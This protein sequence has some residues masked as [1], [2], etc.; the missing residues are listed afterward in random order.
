[1]KRWVAMAGLLALSGCVTFN[2]ERYRSERVRT[3]AV[4]AL[5]AEVDSG[6]SMV[7]PDNSSLAN[8]IN[9]VR[10][11]S[12]FA[13]GDMER[14]RAEQW[15]RVHAQ[16]NQRLTQ[17]L[18]WQTTD[19]KQIVD[20]A[21]YAQIFAQHPNDG[22]QKHALQM[23]PNLL[24]EEGFRALDPKDR[25][26]LL[27]AL[28]VDA[29][30]AVR[31]RFYVGK[32]TKVPGVGFKHMRAAAGFWVFDADSPEPLWIDTQ[33]TGEIS[34]ENTHQVLGIDLQDGETEVLA[35]AATNAFDA[36]IDRYKEWIE[37][38]EKGAPQAIR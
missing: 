25:A 36:L 31:V 7:R 23:V 30:A 29:I 18:G 9:L 1:M 33:A 13:S 12:D 24:R 5:S 8:T 2:V 27:N 10:G 22:F 17:R 14:R 37:L 11:I 15:R 32:H 35:A 4:V 38:G 19:V 26:K 34:E 16:L 21:E 28:G 20:N 3:V 6:E